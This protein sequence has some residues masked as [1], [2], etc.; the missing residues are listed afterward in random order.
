M[1]SDLDHAIM[2]LGRQPGS[3]TG[4]YHRA[5]RVA[6]VLERLQAGASVFFY[7]RPTCDP[8]GLLFLGMS[9]D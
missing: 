4:E 7:S 5:D 9:L 1:H 3:A 8:F 6:M 2:R